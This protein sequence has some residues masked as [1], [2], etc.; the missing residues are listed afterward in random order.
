MLVKTE[1]RILIFQA[2]IFIFQ[3]R[4]CLQARFKAL[5]PTVGRHYFPPGL[6]LTPQPS[7]GLLPVL[8]VLLPGEQ[9][10]NGCEQFV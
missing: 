5:N 2:R 6:Q 8:P 4:P 1:A 10:H 9:R 3:E 7:R